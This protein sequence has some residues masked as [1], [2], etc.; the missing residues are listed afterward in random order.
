M[1][2]NAEAC[3]RRLRYFFDEEGALVISDQKFA[4]DAAVMQRSLSDRFSGASI[5]LSPGTVTV[6]GATTNQLCEILTTVLRCTPVTLELFENNRKNRPMVVPRQCEFHSHGHCVPSPFGAMA[7]P[8]S[9]LASPAP[10]ASTNSHSHVIKRPEPGTGLLIQRQTP[11]PPPPLDVPALDVPEP[12]APPAVASGFDI[13]LSED[14]E[15]APGPMKFAQFG[16]PPDLA[17]GNPIVQEPT[18][19]PEH[20]I[21]AI[22]KSTPPPTSHIVPVE[23]RR[24]DVPVLTRSDFVAASLMSQRSRIGAQYPFLKVFDSRSA[25]PDT[26]SHGRGGISDTKIE[27][28]V[29]TKC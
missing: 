14:T 21:D 9:Q 15:P 23:R 10:P 29:L 26:H 20:I 3:L 8:P 1:A 17:P 11:P 19:S 2:R 22:W 24:L 4:R 27:P 25:E 5:V 18:F 7:V 12:Q 28:S 16:T 6:A 13:D